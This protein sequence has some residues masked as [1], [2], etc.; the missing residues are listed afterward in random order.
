MSFGR[1]KEGQSS[2]QLVKVHKVAQP[3]DIRQYDIA[4]KEIGLLEIFY[5]KYK[6]GPPDFLQS[7]TLKTY[8][9]QAQRLKDQLVKFKNQDIAGQ[10][11]EYHLHRVSTLVTQLYDHNQKFSQFISHRSIESHQTDL[12]QIQNN[13]IELRGLLQQLA[14]LIDP[15]PVRSPIHKPLEVTMILPEVS[16]ITIINVNQTE[17][18]SYDTDDEPINVRSIVMKVAACGCLL[19]CVI[20]GTIGMILFRKLLF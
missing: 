1:M 9:R 3:I 11:H 14:L 16:E 13:M 20:G 19:T 8:N 7:Q 4:E 5:W 17:S 10:F 18:S 15:Q 2:S 12:T 6:A